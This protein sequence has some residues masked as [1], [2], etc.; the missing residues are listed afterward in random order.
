M[1]SLN[2]A[3]PSMSD[4]LAGHYGR[5][6]SPTAGLPPFEATLATVLDRTVKTR[7]RD[8]VLLALREEGLLDPQSLAEADPLEIE[9]ALRSQGV[10]LPRAALAPL[11]RLARWLVDLH[12]GSAA[13]IAGPSSQVSPTQLREELLALNGIGPATADSILLYG[14]NQPVYPLDRATY[15][16]FLRHGWIDP[17]VPYDDARDTIEQ[18][19]PDDA[20]HLGH[21][22]FWFERLGRDFCKAAKAKCERCPLRPFLPAE[23][24]FEPSM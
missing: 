22:S 15:R 9:D 3:F 2:A 8:S 21:L 17:D 19:S 24:P 6:S 5:P 12:H 18:L 11:R 16:I 23:G 20:D 14:L 1:P 10:A 7:K 13:E 4:A